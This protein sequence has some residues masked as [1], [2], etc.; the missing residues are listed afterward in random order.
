MERNKTTYNFISFYKLKKTEKR[1]R[2]ECLGNERALLNHNF[3]R[4]KI[5]SIVFFISFIKGFIKAHFLT[6]PF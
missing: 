5:K 1:K 4:Q 3:R 6:L 2:K